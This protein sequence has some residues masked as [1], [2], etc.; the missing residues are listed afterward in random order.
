VLR[1]GS[2]LT[3]RL[4]LA[5]IRQLPTESATVAELRGGDDFVGWGQDRYL[6]AR[7]I[8][9]VK[10]NTHVFVSANAKRKQ[11]PPEPVERP[12]FKT[13]KQTAP[14]PFAL[15]AGARISA[16]RKKRELANGGEASG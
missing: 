12:D 10:E 6:M 7:L 15:M 8:D 1:P 14:N 2:G 3:P 5:Y 11:R 13:Q 16:V 4:A 9:A